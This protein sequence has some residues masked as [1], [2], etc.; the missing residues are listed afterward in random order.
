[1]FIC[2]SYFLCKIRSYI[3]WSNL[4]LYL[5]KEIKRLGKVRRKNVFVDLLK[6]TKDG[7]KK[8]S[9][10]S[11][12]YQRENCVG[13]CCILIHNTVQQREKY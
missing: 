6:N 9:T 3:I 8:W 11:R 10:R 5:P 4:Y 2:F 12:D 1:M 13:V 7:N